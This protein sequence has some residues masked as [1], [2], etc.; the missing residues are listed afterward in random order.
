MIQP[1]EVQKMLREALPGAEVTVQ[2]QTGT[3]D[4]FQVLVASPSFKGK[5]L[6]EQHL[7]VQRPLKAAIEDGRIH[8][9]SIKTFVPDE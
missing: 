6:V 7:M 3:L 5:T 9:V 2:D 1:E 8:A 4:H